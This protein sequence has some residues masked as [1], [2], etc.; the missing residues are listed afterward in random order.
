MAGFDV[1]NCGWVLA[2]SR[3]PGLHVTGGRWPFDLGD[4]GGLEAFG[5]L[6]DGE[7]GG[8]GVR[9]GIEGRGRCRAA[10]EKA[11]EEAGEA[12]G[13][14]FEEAAGEALGLWGRHGVMLRGPT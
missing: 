4:A 14:E 9:G 3:G 1:G 13:G 12:K 10:G 6:R 11:S 8:M 5:S 2:P 7:V